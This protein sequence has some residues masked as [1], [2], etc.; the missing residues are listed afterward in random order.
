[1]TLKM[2]KLLYSVTILLAVLTGCSQSS[3]QAGAPA[4]VESYLQALVE[5]DLN[6]TV[7]ASCSAWE[8]Q[9]RLEF[10]SFSAVS[11][12]LQ[13][14]SCSEVGQSGEYTLV[15][16]TGAIQANYGNEQMEIDIADR[17]YQTVEE[18][19]DWRMCGYSEP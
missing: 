2:H 4:V 6:R 9:A 13:D 19:G 18:G 10:N 1:M 8:P 12:S 5:R 7:S 17:T 16:C 14:I 11:L 3:S 15:S